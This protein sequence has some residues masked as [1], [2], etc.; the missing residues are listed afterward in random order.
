M[1]VEGRRG[2]ED[3]L[4]WNGRVADLRVRARS[5]GSDGAPRTSFPRHRGRSKDEGRRLPE[6]AERP[7]NG[8]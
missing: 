4:V 6:D 5:R 7:G 1:K 3:L 2:P 8:S